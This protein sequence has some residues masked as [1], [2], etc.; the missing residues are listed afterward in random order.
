MRHHDSCQRKKRRHCE[1]QEGEVELFP[2][3][4]RRHHQQRSEHGTGLVHRGVQAEP[5]AVAHRARGFR[6]QDV[7]GRPTHALAGAFH[8]DEQR[9]ACQLPTKAMCRH[10]DEV[11]QI[12]ERHDGPIGAGA[13]RELAGEVAQRC[14]DHLAEAGNESHLQCRGTE[15]LRNGP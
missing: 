7:A 13:V 10:G 1:W 3:G 5:P 2:V 6:K 11:E 4:D 12:T 14:R 15:P 9:A 8:H